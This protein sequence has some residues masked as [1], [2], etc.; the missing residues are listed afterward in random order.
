MDEFGEVRRE[1][2]GG[3]VFLGGPD[4][5]AHF[6]HGKGDAVAVAIGV[7]HESGEGRGVVRDVAVPDVV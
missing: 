5:R 2:L 4:V 1:N 7:S 6:A 3:E